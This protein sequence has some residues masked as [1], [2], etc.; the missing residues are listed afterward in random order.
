MCYGEGW[1][2]FICDVPVRVRRLHDVSDC[3]HTP[4]EQQR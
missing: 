4:R 3:L 2:T 1:G